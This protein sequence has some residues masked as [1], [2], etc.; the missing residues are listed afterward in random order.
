MLFLENCLIGSLRV[1]VKERS[2]GEVIEVFV[3]W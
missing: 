3:L 1:V 2:L